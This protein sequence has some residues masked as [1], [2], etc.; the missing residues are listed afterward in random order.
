[1]PLIL[2]IL[3]TCVISFV[4]S[5]K[6]LG[7]SGLSLNGWL[8]AWLWSWVIA[9]PTLLL[10]LPL[11]KQMTQTLLQRLQRTQHASQSSQ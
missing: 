5:I 8:Q 6:A 11:V 1:M 7:L 3:M 10:V 9:F 4:S 2:S